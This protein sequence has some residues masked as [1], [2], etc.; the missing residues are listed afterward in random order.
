MT[1]TDMRGEH[2]LHFGTIE[3]TVGELLSGQMSC[4]P[5]STSVCIRSLDSDRRPESLSKYL[6]REGFHGKVQ[7]PGLLLAVRG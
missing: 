7:Q 2:Q 1:P 5:S 3:A 6:T 4:L